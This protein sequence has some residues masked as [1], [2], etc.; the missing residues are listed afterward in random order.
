[1][2]HPDLGPRHALRHFRRQASAKRRLPSTCSM[3]GPVLSVPAPLSPHWP[4]GGASVVPA[5]A[6]KVLLASPAVQQRDERVWGADA[7]EWRP[8][9]WESLSGG[10][11]S[12]VDEGEEP[13]QATALPPYSFMPFSKA[14]GLRTLMCT[15][16]CAPSLLASESLGSRVV[17]VHQ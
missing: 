13:M 10:A 5:P 6:G 15:A 16:R 8:E 4:D 3:C 12:G 2:P 11:V 17:G 1:M 9:R 14:C 7:E